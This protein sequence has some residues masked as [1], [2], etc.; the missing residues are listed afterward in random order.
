MFEAADTRTK[1]SN[2]VLKL[3]LTKRRIIKQILCFSTL[4]KS[5]NTNI[6]RY[7]A[8]IM[9]YLAQEQRT[10]SVTHQQKPEVVSKLQPNIN[11]L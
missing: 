2:A 1:G 4:K 10:S 3:Q 9:P 7:M 6:C 11:Y 8:Y 5:T